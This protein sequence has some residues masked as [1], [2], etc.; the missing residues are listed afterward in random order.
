MIF[1]G[2]HLNPTSNFMCVYTYIY[3]MIKDLQR[4][5]D[6]LQGDLQDVFRNAI[7]W[8]MLIPHVRKVT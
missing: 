2:L 6:R 8:A 4:V 7:L 3:A 1:N 5:S